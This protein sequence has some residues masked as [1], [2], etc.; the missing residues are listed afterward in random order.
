[1][2]PNINNLDFSEIINANNREKQ[3][4]DNI[5]KAIEEIPESFTSVKMLYIP[6]VINGNDTKLFVDT[7]AQ[8][9]IMPLDKAFLHNIENI[10]DYKHQGMVHGVGKQ[11][12]IGKIHFVELQLKDFLIGCSFTVIPDQE[13][14]IIG[15]D[16]LLAHGIIIDLKKRCLIL[17]NVEIPFCEKTD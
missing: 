17:S 5:E 14:I 9:S 7:G 4:N 3:I 16:M 13:D 2:N 8:V 12:I 1:M 6:A 11:E 10:I 15:L